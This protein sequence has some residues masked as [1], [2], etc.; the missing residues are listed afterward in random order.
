M[1]GLHGMAGAPFGYGVVETMG[2][3]CQPTG[4]G[5][6]TDVAA[7]GGGWSATV[8][9]SLTCNSGEA[10]TGVVGGVGEVVDSIALVCAP[11]MTIVGPLGGTG[12]GEFGPLPCPAGS[13]AIG[14]RVTT[15]GG[16]DY[17]LTSAELMCSDNSS[18]AKFGGTT[19]PN[20]TLSCATGDRM[21]GMVGSLSGSV[22]GGVAPRCQNPSGSPITEPWAPQPSGFSGAGPFDCP[23]GQVVKGVQGRQG[24]VVDQIQLMCAA[25]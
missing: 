9:F 10:V 18:T 12:G 8:P 5:A 25:P 14:F 11:P 3:R 7:A 15:G 1:V 24:A 20:T 2:P 19:V 13:A 6:I 22:V 17:A 4:G 16:F 21:V 23:A